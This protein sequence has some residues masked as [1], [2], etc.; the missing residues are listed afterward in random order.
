MK[1]PEIVH[2]FYVVLNGCTHFE[3]KSRELRN[4]AAEAILR[5][6]AKRVLPKDGDLSNFSF[7]MFFLDAQ[8]WCQVQ[9]EAVEVFEDL[10]PVYRWIELLW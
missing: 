3:P 9:C 6:C 2:S 1:N 7:T 4:L 5:K 10:P 8:R